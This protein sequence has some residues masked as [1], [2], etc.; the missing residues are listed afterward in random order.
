MATLA[1][2]LF[3]T[4]A[5]ARPDRTLSRLSSTGAPTTLE[6]V[7]TP[8]TDAGASLTKSA[9]SGLLVLIPQ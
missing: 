8:A 3:T 4:T 7:K 2:P 5:R 9:R 6:R 1:M